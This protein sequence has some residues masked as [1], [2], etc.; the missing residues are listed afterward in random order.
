MTGFHRYFP[1]KSR[2]DQFDISL[3]R[4]RSG[5]QRAGQWSL[6]L[7]EGGNSVTNAGR[8]NRQGKRWDSKL[9]H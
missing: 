7:Q 2:K 6:K 5:A 9:N 8:G 1:V 3:L 4:G